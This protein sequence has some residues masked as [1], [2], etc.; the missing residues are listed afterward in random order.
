MICNT[1][2]NHTA[3]EMIIME[4]DGLEKVRSFSRGSY[5]SSLRYVKVINA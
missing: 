3:A 2:L 4:E 5:E 1:K